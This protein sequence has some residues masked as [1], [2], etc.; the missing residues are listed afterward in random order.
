MKN[1]V[2]ARASKRLHRLTV[3]LPEDLVKKV[4]HISRESG[5]SISRIVAT[6][7]EQHL[8]EEVPSP[9]KTPIHPAVLRK[10]KGR[11]RL[12]ARSPRLRMGRVG[13]W[14]IIDLD[15]PPV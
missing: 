3:S 2:Q 12:V 10:L 7:L 14:R 4:K 15:E 8:V 6:V 9:E 13:S 1:H 5:Q 11:S